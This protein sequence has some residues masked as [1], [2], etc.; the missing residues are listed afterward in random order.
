MYR[1]RYLGVCDDNTDRAGLNEYKD[2]YTKHT[3]TFSLLLLQLLTFIRVEPG[4]KV[5]SFF[6]ITSTPN[7]VA[8]SLFDSLLQCDMCDTTNK[9]LQNL[10]Y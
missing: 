6:L 3:N 1:S 5:S 4:C 7:M 10:N 8:V 2:Q 9:H